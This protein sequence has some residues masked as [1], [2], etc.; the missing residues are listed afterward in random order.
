MNITTNQIGKYTIVREI[1]HG[2]FGKTF[3]VEGDSGKRYVIKRLAPIAGNDPEKALALFKQECDRLREVGHH[4]RI[5]TFIEYFEEDSHHH[6]VQQYVPG[7]TL[8]EESQTRDRYSESE[9]IGLLSDCLETLEFIHGHLIHRDIKPANIIRRT[10]D[11]K[12]CIVDFGSAKVV[13]ETILGKTSATVI[14]SA[15]YAAPEQVNGKVAMFISGLQ[16]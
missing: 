11:N 2:G 8:Q 15:S 9:I 6:I 3:L 14:G 12:L 1:A 16:I 10:I 13:S 7:Q 5:P 4:D